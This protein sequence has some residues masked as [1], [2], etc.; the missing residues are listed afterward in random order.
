MSTN[1]FAAEPELVD[2]T[3]AELT[4]EPVVE[5]ELETTEDQDESESDTELEE[6][7]DS[8]EALEKEFEQ[9]ESAKTALESYVQ[10][11]KQV[12][13][14]G[15]SRQ[16]TTILNLGLKH[17]YSQ[18]GLQLP[19]TGLE[20]Y[21]NGSSVMISLEEL[22]EKKRG[23]LERLWE[24]IKKGFEKLKELYNK[25]FGVTTKVK[26]KVA[27]VEEE[28]RT[29]DPDTNATI[30]ISQAIFSKIYRSINYKTGVMESGLAA[31]VRAVEFAC[32]TYPKALIE[33]MLN[34]DAKSISEGH[35]DENPILSK[36]A[37]SLGPVIKL[38]D[39]T[40]VLTFDKD[41]VTRLGVSRERN[42]DD[43][44]DMPET[45][46]V[47]P[48]IEMSLDIVNTKRIIG[49]IEEKLKENVK[50]IE[51]LVTTA[52]EESKRNL[53]DEDYFIKAKLYATLQKALDT[54]PIRHCMTAPL[55]IAMAKLTVLQLEINA[56]RDDA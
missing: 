22:E 38:A 10:I 49:N 21:D 27:D 3:I 1:Q 5:E 55:S 17:T 31:E 28:L 2:P 35:V 13:P 12:G 43:Y 20:E 42:P 40:T 56:V 32:V 34:V 30:E 54:K 6:V 7:A 26:E 23:L 53:E 41:G 44:E 36:A 19:T 9:V 48:K 50:A 11:L 24:L 46:K 18:L 15:I 33:G 29:T 25:L 37:S 51:K 45:I 8:D 52:L 16:T 4:A 47:R 14:E 39:G